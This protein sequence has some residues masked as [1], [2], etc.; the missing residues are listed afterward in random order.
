MLHVCT[1]QFQVD[2]P[3]LVPVASDVGDGLVVT[4]PRPGNHPLSSEA[5]LRR[6]DFS[7][8]PPSN[9]RGGVRQGRPGSRHFAA[10]IAGSGGTTAVTNHCIEPRAPGPLPAAKAAF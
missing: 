7:I 5:R 4:S 10:L 3:P 8:A 2:S 1:E 9:W 6:W